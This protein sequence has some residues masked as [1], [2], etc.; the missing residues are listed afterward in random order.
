M[1]FGRRSI[2][3]FIQLGGGEVLEVGKIG[4]ILKLFGRD[5]RDL[6]GDT[7]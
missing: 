4:K 2:V 5:V 3:I 6:L 1:N 7:G